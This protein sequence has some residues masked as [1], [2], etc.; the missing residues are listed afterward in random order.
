MRLKTDY[1]LLQFDRV[2]CYPE[3]VYDEL[4]AA[5][6]MDRRHVCDVVTPKFKSQF[7]SQ[8]GD[9]FPQLDTMTQITSR[10]TLDTRNVIFA[11][12]SCI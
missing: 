8:T 6:H 3:E 1:L 5:V 9:L 11:S 4:A 10:Q 2:V 7:P 12:S